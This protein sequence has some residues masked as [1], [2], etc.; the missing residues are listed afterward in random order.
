MPRDEEYKQSVRNR[1]PSTGSH[2][3]GN[4]KLRRRSRTFGDSLVLLDWC[5]RQAGRWEQPE[6]SSFHCANAAFRIFG[7]QIKTFLDK[8]LGLATAAFAVLVV[9]GFIAAVMLG[10]GGQAASEK[11][12]AATALSAPAS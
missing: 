11:C 2:Q 8:Y 12:A 10:G 7:A 6:Q 1:Q 4:F 5:P 3:G 9:G